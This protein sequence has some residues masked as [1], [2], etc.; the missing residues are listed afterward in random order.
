MEP[1]Q[2]ST[3]STLGIIGLAL[4]SG[5]AIVVAV[6]LVSPAALSGANAAEGVV[7]VLLI[8]TAIAGFVVSAL[9]IGLRAGVGRSLGIV[10]MVF[11]AAVIFGFF[12][13]VV[14]SMS[15]VI[16]APG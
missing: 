3:S 8:P 14:M 12:A 15:S 2:R 6:S 1:A 16:Y 10:G 11:G 4:Q 9:A 13:S 7:I 5:L